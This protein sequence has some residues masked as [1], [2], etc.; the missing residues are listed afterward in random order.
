[1]PC[2]ALLWPCLSIILDLPAFALPYL[3]FAFLY[4]ACPCLAW[5]LLA[6]PNFGLGLALLFIGV[7]LH[8]LS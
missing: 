6:L 8:F 4:P 7:T 2:P 1:M 3:V 5:F